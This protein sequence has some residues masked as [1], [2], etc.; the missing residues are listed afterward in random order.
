[1]EITDELFRL[2]ERQAELEGEV[3]AR[4]ARLAETIGETLKANRSFEPSTKGKEREARKDPVRGAGK[5][6][7][8]SQHVPIGILTSPVNRMPLREVRRGGR[9]PTVSRGRQK[10][11][12]GVPGGVFPLSRSRARP[13][14]LLIRLHCIPSIRVLAVIA[15]G[16][17]ARANPESVPPRSMPPDSLVFEA[18]RSGG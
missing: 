7:F 1:M 16:L 18:S 9:V 13:D 8:L 2:R 11:L 17:A 14:R 10:I 3:A 4:I 6:N 12:S 5:T 15:L